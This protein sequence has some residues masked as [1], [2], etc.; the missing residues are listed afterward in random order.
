MQSEAEAEVLVEDTRE[1]QRETFDLQGRLRRSPYAMV[2]GA[3]GIGFVL[4]GGLFTR[5]TGKILRTGL[6]IV[7]MTALPILQR[8]VAQALTGANL[9]SN[10]ENDQ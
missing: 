10:K 4:G 8:E 2:L 7:L 9:K 1:L 5:F 6:R 3:V